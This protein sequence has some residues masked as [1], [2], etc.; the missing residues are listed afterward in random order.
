MYCASYVFVKKSSDLLK[1]RWASLDTSTTLGTVEP[2]FVLFTAE[3]LLNEYLLLYLDVLPLRK[4]DL[5]TA[6]LDSWNEFIGF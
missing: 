1:L 2:N 3:C 4:L 6:L 5:L